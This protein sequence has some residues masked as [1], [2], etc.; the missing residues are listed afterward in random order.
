MAAGQLLCSSVGRAGHGRKSRDVLSSLL[1]LFFHPIAVLPPRPPNPTPFP[2]SQDRCAEALENRQNPRPPE[3]GQ[4][5]ALGCH[6]LTECFVLGNSACGSPVGFP[7]LLA[8]CNSALGCRLSPYPEFPWSRSCTSL[9]LPAPLEIPLRQPPP[10]AMEG[11]MFSIALPPPSAGEAAPPQLLVFDF[12]G[13]DLVL[14][15]WHPPPRTPGDPAKFC[16]SSLDAP[17]VCFEST[18]LTSPL[19][20]KWAR[21]EQKQQSAPSVSPAGW[22]SCGGDSCQPLL[23]MDMPRPHCHPVTFTNTARKGTPAPKY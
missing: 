9:V 21:D 16:G 18:L 5:T 6:S 17:L 1:C 12:P 3:S 7:V 15:A 11:S 10:A 20:S 8:L 22:T 14:P 2:S 23:S 19:S 4:G 13:P